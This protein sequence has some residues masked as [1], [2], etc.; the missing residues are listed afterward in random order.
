MVDCMCVWLY[1]TLGFEHL[2]KATALLGS[3]LSIEIDTETVHSTCHMH[4]VFFQ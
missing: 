3:E 2:T 4:M 1:C